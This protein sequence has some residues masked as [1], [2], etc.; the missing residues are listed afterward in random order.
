[1]IPRSMLRICEPRG[2]AKSMW[3]ATAFDEM[4]AFGTEVRPGYEIVANWLKGYPCRDPDPAPARGGAAGF[5]RIGTTFNVYGDAEVRERLILRHRAARHRPPLNG[6][7]WPKVCASARHRAQHVP[8]GRSLKG[9][10]AVRPASF[11]KTRLQEPC[12]RPEMQG[13]SCPTTSG[14]RSPVSTS[15]AS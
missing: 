3:V 1:M 10:V 6:R 15:S 9:E 4:S 7:S 11:R 13:I 5:R 12:Y 8:E 2:D 14:C